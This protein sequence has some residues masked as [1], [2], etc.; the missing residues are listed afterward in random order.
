MLKLGTTALLLRME[1]EQT[2]Y[3]RLLS[4]L[5]GLR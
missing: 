3:A 5:N 2:G 4:D 1:W